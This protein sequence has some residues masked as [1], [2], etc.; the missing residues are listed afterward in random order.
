MQVR[1]FSPRRKPITTEVAADE[2]FGAIR[3]RL[4]KELGIAGERGLILHQG[5]TVPARLRACEPSCSSM[6][7]LLCAGLAAVSALFDPAR[8]CQ[9]KDD[10]PASVRLQGAEEVMAI[11]CVNTDEGSLPPHL[12]NLTRRLRQVIFFME[13]AEPP[14]RA[15]AGAGNAFAGPGMF[16]M[17]GGRG[18]GGMPTASSGAAG[19]AAQLMQRM[20]QAQ[21]QPQGGPA[22]VSL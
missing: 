19:L 9:V 17:P 21:Q 12:S 11:A 20:Q 7:R 14:K 5:Q 1:V 13:I 22:Q 10:E 4:G 3:S 2:T 8:A 18:S 6:H 15:R 16:G